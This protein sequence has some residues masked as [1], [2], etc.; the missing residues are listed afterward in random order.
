MQC[1]KSWGLKDK[2]LGDGL[3]VC[4]SCYFE[5]AGNKNSLANAHEFNFPND[6]GLQTSTIRRRCPAIFSNRF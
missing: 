2:G 5:M 3:L 1:G 6:P 4:S